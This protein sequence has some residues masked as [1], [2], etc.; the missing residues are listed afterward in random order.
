MVKDAIKKYDAAK[1]IVLKKIDKASKYKIAS[2]IS[3]I[4][5]IDKLK[6]DARVRNKLKLQDIDPKRAVYLEQ[7]AKN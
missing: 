4:T 5:L 3:R 7:Y 6:A 1:V 2:K